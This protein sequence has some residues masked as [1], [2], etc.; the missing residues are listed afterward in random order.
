MLEIVLTFIATTCFY[1]AIAL[2]FCQ[3]VVWHLQDN[4]EA[5]KAVTDHVLVPLLGRKPEEETIEE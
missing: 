5:V 3:R 2:F 1:L 4:P